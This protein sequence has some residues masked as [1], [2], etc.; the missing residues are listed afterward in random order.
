MIVAEECKAVREGVGLLDISGFSRFEVSGPNA[1]A[2]LDRLMASTLPKPGRAR[3][4]PCWRRT[5]KL[6]GDLTRV[7]LG[8]WHLVDH[9]SY[10][11]RE[12]HMRWF[13]DH[14]AG[15]RHGARSGRQM[16]GF[17]L[18]GPKSREVIEKL[19]EARSAR[20][21]SWAAASSTSG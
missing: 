11:L 15:R 3:L 10:Y 17:S 4:R 9:G 12:W 5:G 18:A 16:A 7:Q 13:H 14:M 20:C 8:R 19:T 21:P 6:K 1:E 2:W